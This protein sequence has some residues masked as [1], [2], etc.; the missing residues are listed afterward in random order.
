MKR[1]TLRLKGEKAQ[2]NRLIRTIMKES[3]EMKETVEDQIITIR[4][5]KEEIK[6]RDEV[7]SSNYHTIQVV[8]M[9]LNLPP[10]PGHEIPINPRHASLRP[11]EEKYRNWRSTS[12]C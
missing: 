3:N 4:K 2:D 1:N 11:C 6:E 5:L 8:D 9:L 10:S 7:I 12:S